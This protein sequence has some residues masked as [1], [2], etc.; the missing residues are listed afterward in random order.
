MEGITVEKKIKGSK[1]YMLYIQQRKEYSEHCVWLRFMLLLQ[2]YITKAVQPAKAKR[3]ISD[4]MNL[5]YMYI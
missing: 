5:I 2:K 4:K 3:C 1:C